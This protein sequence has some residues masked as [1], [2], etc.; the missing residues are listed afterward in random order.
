MRSSQSDCNLSSYIWHYEAAGQV[1]SAQKPL[2]GFFL[3]SYIIQR[4]INTKYIIIELINQSDQNTCIF[5]DIIT[6][7]LTKE[8]KT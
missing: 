2:Q 8:S 5:T 6:K 7:C 4:I 3:V 1:G